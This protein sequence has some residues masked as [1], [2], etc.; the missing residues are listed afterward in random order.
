MLR[1]L[2]ADVA[3]GCSAT[4][5]NLKSNDVCMMTTTTE[6]RK[7]AFFFINTGVYDGNALGILFENELSG[8]NRRLACPENCFINIIYFYIWC[9]RSLPCVF[10]ERSVNS[11]KRQIVSSWCKILVIN[12]L[13]FK[14]SPIFPLRSLPLSLVLP[15]NASCAMI[16]L[17]STI[18]K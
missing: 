14:N 6:I 13:Q 7:G 2:N 15:L 5:N 12:S 4:A 9:W 11:S 16:I 1:P 18:L 17:T 3:S 8:Y 10:S